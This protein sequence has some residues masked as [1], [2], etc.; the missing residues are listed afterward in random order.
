ME[1]GHQGETEGGHQ[2]E[3]EGGHQEV[4]AVAAAAACC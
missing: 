4:A 3:M 1:G 2:E